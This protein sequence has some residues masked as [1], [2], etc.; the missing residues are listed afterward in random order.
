MSASPSPVPAKKARVSRPRSAAVAPRPKRQR[1]NKLYRISS[2]ISVAREWI[3]HHFHLAGTAS[4]EEVQARA[5]MM[6]C[7]MMDQLYKY[8]WEEL[9]ECLELRQQWPALYE[10]WL[11]NKDHPDGMERALFDVP[12]KIEFERS[13]DRGFIITDS[14]AY[15]NQY[16]LGRVALAD[17]PKSS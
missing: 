2:D 13:S 3:E 9:H 11:A 17:L 16:A 5:Y 8:E 14:I 7:T 6:Q 10:R 12:G 1:F 4:D 15:P